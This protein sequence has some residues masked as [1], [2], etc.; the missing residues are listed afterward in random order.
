MHDP[1]LSNTN[2]QEKN[3]G[4]ENKIG[5]CTKILLE[6]LFIDFTQHRRF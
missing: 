6:T 3:F 5:T 4:I 2:R 1:S